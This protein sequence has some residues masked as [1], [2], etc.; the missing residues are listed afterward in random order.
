MQFSEVFQRA[1]G[2]A[3]YRFQAELAAASAPPAVLA[4]PT[5]S[6]K[7]QALIAGWLY[8]RWRGEAPRR[9]VYALPMR[10]LVEQTTAVAVAMRERLGLTA[11]ELSVHVLMGGVEP[12]DWR[13]HPE[14]DQIL[15]GT[16]DMLLSRALNRGYAESRFAWPVAFGLLSN[17]CRW[18]F[19]EV[20]LMGPARATSAQLD[21][22]RS[23]LGT[24]MPCETVWASATVDPDALVTV[25]RPDLGAVLTLPAADREGPLAARLE[26]RKTLERVDVASVAP[27][28]L[29]SVIAEEVLGCHRPGTRT[30]VVLNTVDRAQAAFDALAKQ[31]RDQNPA[32]VLLHSRF[33]PPDRLARMREATAVVDPDGPGVILVATQVVEAGLDLSAALLVTETAPFSSIV[34]RLGRCNRAGEHDDAGVVWLDAGPFEPG[35]RGARAAAPYLPANLNATREALL[36]LEGRS[37]SPAALEGISVPEQDETPVLLRRHDLLDLFDTTPDLSGLDVDVA[38]F[39]RPD[40][41]RSVAVFFRELPT[42]AP[43]TL[44]DQPAAARD[45]LVSV[46]LGQLARRDCWRFDELDELWRRQPAGRVP[47]GSTVLLD[48]AAGGYGERRGWDPRD[49]APVTPTVPPEPERP[50]GLGDDPRSF[51]SEPQHLGDHLQAAA[52]AAREL[53]AALE[54]PER[55]R[56]ALVAAAALHDVGKAHPVFQETLLAAM[57]EDADAGSLWAKSGRRGGRHRRAHFRHELASAL[58]IQRAATA[59]AL[60]DTELVAYLVAAHHGKVRLSI[61][62]APDERV[63]ADAPEGARLALGIL[64]GDELP[65]VPTPLG[66]LAQT[67]IDLACMELGAEPSWSRSAVRLRDDEALGP[68]RLAAL[69]A[70][71]RIA[72][73]RASA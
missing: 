48:A 53:G 19:D 16:I 66:L 32:L 44:H 4:V 65:A 21:G 69:E 8:R 58:A 37:L 47:P 11:E 56:D 41:D 55:E 14:R 31:A 3:P 42:P 52:A 49:R 63:P 15:I 30:L 64:D 28:R 70:L 6:G 35:A 60:A 51:A 18:V 17:D 72:D 13:E 9:L 39:I 2:R 57:G 50:E 26:A 7:T 29:A 68:F 1:T 45:E 38:P 24:L 67:A 61:R 43:A 59:L 33:R 46:P 54:L 27:N 25:D 5:G 62:P 12:S 40:D 34:Q 71:V 23:K 20:Q 73:W 36:A 10:T 22:L